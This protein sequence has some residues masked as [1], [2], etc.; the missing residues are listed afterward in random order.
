MMSMR[1]KMW[2]WLKMVMRPMIDH[3]AY[4]AIMRCR[5]RVFRASP[6]V[7]GWQAPSIWVCRP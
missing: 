5:R 4:D 3:D 1:M 6:C 2:L 7:A